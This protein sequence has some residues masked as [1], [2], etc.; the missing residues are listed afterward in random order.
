M[1]DRR[2]YGPFWIWT[3]DEGKVEYPFT[4]MERRPS[5]IYRL[6]IVGDKQ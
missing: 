4:T 3:G 6:G 5:H 1:S 2:V